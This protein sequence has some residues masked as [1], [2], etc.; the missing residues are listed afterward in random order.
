MDSGFYGID[1]YY[2]LNPGG[3]TYIPGSGDAGITCPAATF[4]GD[5]PSGRHFGGSNIAFA[6]GHAKWIKASTM[7]DEARKFDRTNHTTSAW[8][9]FAN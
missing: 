4:A 6:D 1:P 7:L 2:A 3:S 8:D 5:C 9:P